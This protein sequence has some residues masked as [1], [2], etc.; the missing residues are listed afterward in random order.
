MIKIPEAICKNPHSA[1]YREWIETN[2]LG[3]YSSSTIL[4]LNSRRYHGL[5][6]AALNPPVNRYVIVSKVEETIVIQGDKYSLSTNQYPGNV[7]P[8]GYKYLKEFRLTPFPK[9]VYEVG[10]Y[11]I[12]KTVFMIHGQNA[13]AVKYLV[14]PD[15][16]DVELYI[17]P[18]LAYR[19]FHS[20]QKGNEPLVSDIHVSGKVV[21]ITPSAPLPPLYI[22]HSGDMFREKGFWYNNFEY[23]EEAYRGYECHED[24]YNPGYLIHTFYQP[25]H[26]DAWVLFSLDPM[27][28]SGIQALEDK[29]ISRRS[30]LVKNLEND[31]GFL[32]PLVLAADSFI[33]ERDKKP[34]SSIIAGY[35]W[36]GDWTRDTLISLPGLTLATGR[37]NVAKQILHMYSQKS[38]SGILPNFFDENNNPIYNSADTSL[39]FF[40]A[41]YKYLQY[42]D[43]YA[44]AKSLLPLLREILQSYT[45]GTLYGICTNEQKLITFSEDSLPLTWMDT[46][47]G[48]SRSHPRKGMVVEINALWYQALKIMEHLMM[49]F[50]LLA[51]AALYAHQAEEVRESFVKVFWSEKLQYLYDFVDGD[52]YEETLRPNQILATGLPFSVLPSPYRASVLEV[53]EKQLL[54]PFG[55]RTLN[56]DSPCYAP[57]YRGGER[58]R[59]YAYHQGSVWVWLLGF[60]ASTLVNIGGRTPEV[61]D[62]IH[63]LLSVFKEHLSVGCIGSVSEIFDGSIP[64]YFRGAVSQAWSVAELLRVSCEELQNDDGKFKPLVSSSRIYH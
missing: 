48:E 58:N 54:T 4:G 23:A 30:K 26:Y 5:L 8:E 52:Y 29:E 7:F 33:V 14:Y 27:V 32:E 1:L 19:P 56:S 43:D 60:Y 11:R 34:Q 22:Y 39:W 35:H 53:I 36:F 37:F 59:K 13:V 18:M 31:K 38:V 24:L 49:K 42:T 51:D 9:F 28:V 16:G 41:L 12:E 6:V 50:D 2:G 64:Y 3:G 47:G 62:R 46:I 63:G 57:H 61:R 20:M 17:R 44:F 25:Q 55:L 45:E 40:Y 15:R 10:D 21:K